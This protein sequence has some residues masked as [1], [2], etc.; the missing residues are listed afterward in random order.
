MV[1]WG[2]AG[3]SIACCRQHTAVCWVWRGAHRLLPP[4]PQTRSVQ[5][6]CNG[7]LVNSPNGLE[8]KKN[9]PKTAQDS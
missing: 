6:V 9:G 4:T 7:K 1:L 2:L 3:R 8:Q 5:C